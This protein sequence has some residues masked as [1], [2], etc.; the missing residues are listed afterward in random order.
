LRLKSRVLLVQT[1]FRQ[2]TVEKIRTRPFSF[3]LRQWEKEQ[4]EKEEKEEKE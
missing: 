2:L 3:F 4:E 1:F